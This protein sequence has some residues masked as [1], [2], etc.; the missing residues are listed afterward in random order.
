MA[1]TQLA[2]L[3]MSSDEV[4][5]FDARVVSMQAVF[6]LGLVVL[7]LLGRDL[8]RNVAWLGDLFATARCSALGT[9]VRCTVAPAAYVAL[10]ARCN[11]ARVKPAALAVAY[12]CPGTLSNS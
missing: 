5:G 10:G 9:R 8:G 7:H 12:A 1:R 4:R 6:L 3:F 2:W 11:V